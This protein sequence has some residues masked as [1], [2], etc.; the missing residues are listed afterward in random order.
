MMKLALLVLSLGS[1]A[2][3]HLAAMPSRTRTAPVAM[4]MPAAATQLVTLLGR[5]PEEIQ[6]S[7]VMDAVE[8]LYEVSEVPFSVGDVV[9]EP[10]QNM[11]S[12]KIFSFATISKLDAQATLQLF[13]DYYRKVPAAHAHA[14]A[15]VCLRE[16]ARASERETLG[17]S[18]CIK[19]LTPRTPSAG[20]T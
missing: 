12:A 17:C 2:A 6:F 5:A 4:Q 13:G 20:R 18:P 8:E 11:G 7:L 3:F 9:S 15:R 16:R 19:P 1:S 10:G 14:R